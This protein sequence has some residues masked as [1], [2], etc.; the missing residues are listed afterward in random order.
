MLRRLMSPLHESNTKYSA[1]VMVLGVV[2]SKG[3]IMLPHFFETGQRVNA[4]Q[5][6]HVEFLTP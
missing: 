6:I 1:S 3:D 4:K 2:S 5:Y